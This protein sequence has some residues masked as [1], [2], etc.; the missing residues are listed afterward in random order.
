MQTRIRVQNV[1]KKE[2]LKE[3]KRNIEKKIIYLRGKQGEKQR[4]TEDIGSIKCS[5]VKGVWIE[6]GSVMLR[7]H[8]YDHTH[9]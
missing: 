9:L 8:I 6:M 4:E 1:F 5:V 7:R 3:T 2:K